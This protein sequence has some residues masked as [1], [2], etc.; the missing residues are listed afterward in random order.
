MLPPVE[1][2]GEDVELGLRNNNS[3]S[4]GRNNIAAP[5]PSSAPVGYT[6]GEVSNQMHTLQSPP[7]VTPSTHSPGKEK[8]TI[9]HEEEEEEE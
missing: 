8:F 9:S 3:N 7:S 4:I 1:E 5:S 2:D 6:P